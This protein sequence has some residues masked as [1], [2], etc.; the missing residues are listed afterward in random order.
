[1]PSHQ[2]MMGR[3]RWL[4]LAPLAPLAAKAA[5]GAQRVREALPAIPPPPRFLYDPDT[6]L[7]S[8]R[9]RE[10]VS[11]YRLMEGRP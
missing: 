7:W 10:G 11:S 4:T 9:I 6:G 8:E 3:R 1:M 2:P 5:A